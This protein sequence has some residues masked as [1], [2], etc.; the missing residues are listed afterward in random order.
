MNM[1]LRSPS[2]SRCN[3]DRRPRL[4]T[5]RSVA[6]RAIVILWFDQLAMTLSLAGHLSLF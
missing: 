6:L 2:L 3:D 5:W 4:Y 1:S